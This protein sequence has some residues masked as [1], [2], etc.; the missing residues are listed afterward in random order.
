MSLQNLYQIMNYEDLIE[1]L[2]GGTEEFIVLTVVLPKTPDTLKIQLKKYV[3]SKAKKFP[4][5]TFLYYILKKTDP[6]KISIL[7]KNPADYPKMCHIYDVTQ[8]L[9]EITSIDCLEAVDVSFKKTENYYIED[10]KYEQEKEAKFIQQTNPNEDE[11]LEEIQST[12]N[13][14]SNNNDNDNN[15]NN[16]NNN[17]NTNYNNT[18]DPTTEKKKHH[19]KIS[20]FVKK[21]E[22]FNIEFLKDCKARKEEEH[23]NK[24]NTKN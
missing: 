4:N 6:D 15:N 1:L 9:N 8:L 7:G 14:N 20:L 5:V 18:P 2:T 21:M 24:K 3:K 16:N 19:E 10:L 17:T 12:K 11:E 22:E 13:G 23:N